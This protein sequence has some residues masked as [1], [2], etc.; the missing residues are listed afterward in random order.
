MT[1]FL[2][3]D[4]FSCVLKE[5]GIYVGTGSQSSSFVKSKKHIECTGSKDPQGEEGEEGVHVPWGGGGGGGGGV[6]RKSTR[7]HMK[8]SRIV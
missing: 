8:G 2:Q 3:V 6:T 4:H 1:S 7:E 5:K